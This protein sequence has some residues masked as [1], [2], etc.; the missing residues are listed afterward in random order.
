MTTLKE[1]F[2]DDGEELSYEAE[3]INLAVG[4]S[5]YDSSTEP[6]LEKK[7]GEFKFMRSSWGKDENDKVYWRN[8]EIPSHICTREELGLDPSENG[9]NFL[10]IKPVHISEISSHQKKLRCIDKDELIVSGHYNSATA[11]VIKVV[12]KKCYKKDYCAKPEEI[13][14][15][16]RY[17]FMLLFSN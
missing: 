12:L 2:F 8:E 14:D 16:F 13:E 5:P 17:K 7:Y 10:P 3:G 1:D 11:S 4:F 9:S 6:L 15:F